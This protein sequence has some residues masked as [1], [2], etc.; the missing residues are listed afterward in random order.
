MTSAIGASS[1]CASLLLAFLKIVVA[2][3]RHEAIC[4]NRRQK[5]ER[6]SDR[7]CRKTFLEFC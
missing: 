6:G 1:F 7:R 4:Y 2:V 3:H 5:A